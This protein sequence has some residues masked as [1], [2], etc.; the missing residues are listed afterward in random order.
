MIFNVDKA[1]IAQLESEN[2]QLKRENNEI[3][4][5]LIMITTTS[6]E[7]TNELKR[8]IEIAEKLAEENKRLRE[9][10]NGTTPETKQ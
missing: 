9:P 2:N 8:W 10:T 6:K 4:N 1:K 7:M 3:T 5:H